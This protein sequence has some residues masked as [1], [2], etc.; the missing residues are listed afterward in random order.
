MV[1]FRYILY[2]FVE[3]RDLSSRSNLQTKQ[4]RKKNV[5]TNIIN[6]H[7]A[8]TTLFTPGLICLIIRSEYEYQEC[9]GDLRHMETINWQTNLYDALNYAQFI[10]QPR[11]SDPDRW[12]FT[13]FIN[14]SLGVKL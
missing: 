6:H 12:I 9:V 5:H 14:E 2:V 13:K 1:S 7:T 11:A 4:N 3:I 10:L 8:S